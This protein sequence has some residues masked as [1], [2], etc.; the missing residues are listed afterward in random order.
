MQHPS[1]DYSVS[2]NRLSVTRLVIATALAFSILTATGTHVPANAT[3]STTVTFHYK[4]AVGDTRTWHM[5]IWEDG[6]NGH[7]FTFSST[8]S[9]G[10][11]LTVTYDHPVSQVGFIVMTNAVD[12]VKDIP[13]NRF[14][15]ITGPSAEVWL[16]GHDAGTYLSP[17]DIGKPAATYQPS[18]I[19]NA[20]LYEVNVRQFSQ[21][22]NFAGV[23]AQI[24]RLKSLGVDILW[25]MPIH[26]IGQAHRLGSLGSPYSV[27]NYTDV[28]SE[29]GNMAD[30]QALIAA[31]HRAGMHVI[32]DWVGN[33]TAWDNPWITAHPEWYTHDGS[34]NIIPPNS[35]WTDVADL[36]YGNT[37]MQNAMIAAMKFWVQA[38]GIDGFR[39]DAASMVPTSFWNR[40]AK[41]IN[42]I[43]PV[44]WLAEDWDHSDLLTNA[45][46]SNYDGA[47]TGYMESVARGTASK[48]SFQDQ[49]TRR[50]SWY[51]SGA[52][53]MN[54]VTNHDLNAGATEM[55]RMGSGL[56]QA[57][58]L[59]FTAAGIPMIY[60]GQ[61]I[62]YNHRFAFFEHDPITWSAS[63]C[64]A[65]YKK[66][67]SLKTRNAA[68]WNGSFGGQMKA[69]A[70]NNPKVVAFKRLKGTN[71]VIVVMNISSST[72]SAT[73]TT[74]LLTKTYQR[75]S[76]GKGA[77][78]GNIVR[79][80]LAPYGYEI[81][82]TAGQ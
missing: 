74:G 21:A 43:K 45:F 71:S 30:F 78:F 18:W 22:G 13:S 32:L 75:F 44:Y 5:W 81:F 51:P 20:V 17:S 7:E 79:Q 76:N 3:S 68:L 80:S 70:T 62:C 39:A 31:A 24:P 52:I 67:I 55:S 40:A 34:G 69:I 66:L 26:P 46:L 37:D 82:S 50:A 41:E 49:I 16:R 2:L 58:A 8:D 25:L 65:L 63:S 54:Y 59:S 15:S 38:K 56:N 27:A 36:N 48:T 12:W 57:A 53:P 10:K 23:T 28:N 6:Q 61:E 73:V 42:A 64:T 47:L 11:V 19:K 35:D 14:V 77:K 4:Q 29:Y 9:F 60:T 72:Q 33:H 1:Y